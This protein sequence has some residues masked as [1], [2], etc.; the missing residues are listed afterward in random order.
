[1]KISRLK[2]ENSKFRQNNNIYLNRIK[3]IQNAYDSLCTHMHRTPSF[4]LDVKVG[5]LTTQLDFYMERDVA[6]GVVIQSLNHEIEVL[7]RQL[8]FN[9]TSQERKG[10]KSMKDLNGF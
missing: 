6:Q 3:E 2:S 7:K 4:N 8:R 1:V 5:E 10:V 9:R